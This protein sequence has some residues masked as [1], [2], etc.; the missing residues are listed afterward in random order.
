M[1]KEAMMFLFGLVSVA[2]FLLAFT[3]GPM[4]PF[5]LQSVHA[6]S[7]FEGRSIPPIVT[8]NWLAEHMNDPG[9]VI[10][11]IRSDKAYAAG[12][13]PGAVNVPMPSWIVKKNGLLLEVPED[14]ALFQTL[15]SSG[16]APNS[17]VVVVNT[18]NH[19][20]PLADT[21]RVA[22][23]LIYAGLRNASVLSGGYDKWIK[24]KRPVSDAPSKPAPVAFKGKVRKEM[25][26]TKKDVKARL[27][28]CT[29]M[30][31]R[32]PDVYFGVVK[33]PFCARPGHISGATCWPVPWMWTDDGAYKDIEAIKATARGVVGSDLSKEIIVYCGVGGY[34]AAAW[35]VLHDVLGYS[36][37]KIYDG[38]AQ[39]WTADPDAPVSV[40]VWE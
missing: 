2:S 22:D 10:I 18:A 23:M 31:A 29:L 26:V 21:A 33:E 37:V 19:P 3:M 40:F 32:T 5:S 17:K 30:D 16:I 13:I 25:F 39:E 28:K 8:T 20:Y 9:V 27:G 4:L 24:E 1:K 7:E 38:S 36:N 11:D 34:A 12:H 6:G 14:T 15:G 35:F